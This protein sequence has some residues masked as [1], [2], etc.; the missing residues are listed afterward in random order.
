MKLLLQNYH[1]ETRHITI[2]SGI[3]L[4]III[5]V[6]VMYNKKTNLFNTKTAIIILFPI[7]L[8]VHF[9]K[10]VTVIIIV[11]RIL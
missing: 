2:N 7:L 8:E 10:I 9:I 5:I 1:L 4:P 3:I 11:P 6:I